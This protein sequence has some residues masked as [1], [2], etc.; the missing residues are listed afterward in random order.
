MAAACTGLMLLAG[1]CTSDDD[2]FGSAFT[3]EPATT[4]TTASVTT[5][6]VPPTTVATVPPPP[7]APPPPPPAVPV[8]P[9][10][11]SAGARGEAVRML[12]QRLD[13]LRFD[14]GTVDDLYD[15][16]TAFGVTA[17][18]KV[19]GLPRSGKATPDVVNV[20]AVAQPPPPM[21]PGGGATR[22]EIDLGR[23]VL[24]LFQGD[25][26]HRVLPISSGT[27]KRYCAEG[28]CG[29]ATTPTGSFKVERRISGWRKSR[30]GRLYNPLYFNGGIAIHGFPSVPA[31]PA[32]HGCVRIPMSASGWFPAMVPDGTPVYVLARA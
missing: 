3:G 14:V 8:P 22:V 13:A 23:Q 27:G 1:A 10:G 7:P 17:F 24:F 5:T 26:L 32:S 25:V 6:T 9:E 30:L 18:Q 15:R 21:V 20:L 12:E 19:V 11:L 28:S 29:I 16:N 31:Q 4:S 2:G